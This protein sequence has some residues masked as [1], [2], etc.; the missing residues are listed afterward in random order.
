MG[1]YFDYWDFDIYRDWLKSIFGNRKNY[2]R[3]V[4][5][6]QWN[7]T[8]AWLINMGCRENL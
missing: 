3:F 5:E 7:E 1:F 6:K 2:Y 8:R 4:V